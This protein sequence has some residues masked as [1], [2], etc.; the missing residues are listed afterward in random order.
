MTY[1]PGRRVI[2]KLSV[3]NSLQVIVLFLNDQEVTHRWL[4]TNCFECQSDRIGTF[5]TEFALACHMT[6]YV[7]VITHQLRWGGR[8]RCEVDGWISGTRRCLRHADARTWFAVAN[9]SD[10]GSGAKSVNPCC[11][12]AFPPSASVG[13]GRGASP[14]KPASI[15]NTKWSTT[16]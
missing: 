16:G 7:E 2:S 3:N 5:S 15:R 8:C 14:M 11:T 10:A 13:P 4:D 12:S 9:R 1:W 6:K